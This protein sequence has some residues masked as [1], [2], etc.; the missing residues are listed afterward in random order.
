MPLLCVYL[1]LHVSIFPLL[2]FICPYLHVGVLTA[3][4]QAQRAGTSHA[5]KSEHFPPPLAFSLQSL[6]ARTFTHL[7]CTQTCATPA[8][9]RGTSGTQRH[10]GA[11]RPWPASQPASRLGSN[12]SLVAYQAHA[13][14]SLDESIV[15]FLV[16]LPE[17]IRPHPISV[18]DQK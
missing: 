13:G 2:V 7:L 4:V 18:L 10:L 17:T 14:L 12:E 11:K 16:A 8:C 5:A 3:G 6:Y 9:G 1:P 15:F